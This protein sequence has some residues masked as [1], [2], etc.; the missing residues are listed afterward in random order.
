MKCPR[1]RTEFLSPVEGWRNCPK[2]GLAKFLPEVQ[3]TKK[4]KADAVVEDPTPAPDVEP[5]LETE[6]TE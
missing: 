5:E 3:E 6:S 1:C 4:T 2:C